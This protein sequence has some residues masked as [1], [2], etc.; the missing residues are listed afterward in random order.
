MKKTTHS[1]K[2]CFHRASVIVSTVV[3]AAGIQSVTAQSVGV[4]FGNG[5]GTGYASG[6][7]TDLLAPTNSAG[8]PGFAQTN[9]NNLG[10]SG[11]SAGVS[12]TPVVLTNSAG[13]ATSLSVMWSSAGV[14]STGAGSSLGTPDGNLMDGYLNSYSPGAATALGDSVYYNSAN[15]NPL[16][17]VGGLNAWCSA[18][19]AVSYN[20]VLYTTGNSYWETAEG[21]LESVTGSPFTFSMSEGSVLTPPLYAVDNGNYSGSYVHVTSTNSSAQTYGGNYMVFYGQTN[22]AV[23]IRLQSIGYGAGLSGFQ[24]VPVPG[25]TATASLSSTVSGANLIL[26]WTG[27]TLQSATNLAGPWTSITTT[28]PYTAAMTN[29]SQFFRVGPSTGD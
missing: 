23:L 27:A 17:Y 22:D 21:Y 8:A 4:H 19:G 2:T 16:A 10:A 6:S 24:I 20:V 12:G 15:N 1:V 14:G 28:S 26:T 3:L 7:S 18:Q 5:G 11:D 25:P 29:S 9:W 13:A